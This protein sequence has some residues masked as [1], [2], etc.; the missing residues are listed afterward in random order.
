[1]AN[2][3]RGGTSFIFLLCVLDL[4]SGQIRYS[5]PEELEHGAIVGNIAEDLKLKIWE[6]SAR[7]FR[8]ISD[9]RKQ[10]VEVDLE[11]GNLFVNERIDRE[12]ICK[13]SSTCSLSFEITLDNPLEMHRVVVEILDVNDNSPSFAKD[14]FS[15]EISELIAPG[16]RFP[17]ES[18][19][20][21]DV[22]TNTVSTYQVSPNEHFGIKMQTRN[23]GSKSA[24]LFLEKSLDHEQQP[25]FQL[26]LTA[27]DAGIPQR[28][29]TTRIII[30]VL[31]SNDNAPV[32][33]HEIYRT[34]IA[35]N[36]PLGTLVLKINA[37]DLD[38]GSNAELSYYFTRHVSQRIREMFKLDPV[39]GEISVQ[40][41]L[42][43]EESSVYELDVQA[44]DNAPPGM[45]VHAKVMV[46]LI[47]VNDNAPEVEV[48]SVSSTIPEDAQPGTVIAVIRVTDL[49]SGQ[50]AQ[51]HC[52]VPVNIPFKLQKSSRN[53]YKLITSDILDRETAP[54]YNI[55][56]SAWDGG[57]P[58]LSTRKTILVSISDVNDNA[59]KFTQSLYNVYLMENNTP[60]ASIFDVTALDSDMDKNGY[61][62]YSILENRIQEGPRFVTINSENGNIYSLRSF[63]Y[64]QL[65]YFQIKV[66]A[67]DTGSPSLSSTA[68]VNVI[69]LDQNDNA[70]VIVSPS[71]WNSSASIE[72]MPQSVYP[73]Y[74]ATKV[75]ATDADSGQNARLSYQLLEASDP[76]L[77]TV[78]LLSGEIRA[79]RHFREQDIV[80]E[81]LVLSIKDNGQP[82]LSTTVTISFTI[83]SNATQ[84]YSGRTYEPKHSEYLSNLNRYLIIILASTS[85]L[86]LAIIIFLVF[87]KFKQ[88]R[89]IAEDGSS[90]VCCDRRRNSNN[91]FNR[92]PAGNEPLSYPGSGQVEGFGYTVCLTPESS[93]SDFLFLKPGHPTLP[94]SEVNI[95]N[96]NAM[97]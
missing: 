26:V 67:Q 27:L 80:T 21:P 14:E 12:Q 82:S 16:A 11:K 54:L 35:E 53:K 42:D 86:F 46:G 34:S 31:D 52:Q 72:I 3:R 58:A 38:E 24:E 29:G 61:V 28:S 44:V 45:A 18:A 91:V 89:N 59:P 94:F 23:D 37:Y 60:G 56:I 63:D 1:M 92:R 30:T 73:E 20:D 57:S 7:K 96:T 85:C 76:S 32:F 78:G 19:Q 2:T 40:S 93:K 97:I 4:V 55:S 65:K 51:I 10:N 64:E 79:T 70:P 25:T 5:I 74:L 81:R 41:V 87:L 49:D 36:A 43:F 9:D 17:V 75:I 66:Q 71:M 48:T 77:F 15:L 22:G 50:N 90:T 84:N 6:L 47:D 8:L 69:I 95:R 83:L 33:D 39:T 68:T 88:E 62:V 13:Q